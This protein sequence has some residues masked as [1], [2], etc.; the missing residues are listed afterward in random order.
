M[1]TGVA[2]A[3]R[4]EEG[5]RRARGCDERHVTTTPRTLGGSEIDERGTLPHRSPLKGIYEEA[6]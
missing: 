5:E 1:L 4:F 3:V 2:E 6:K